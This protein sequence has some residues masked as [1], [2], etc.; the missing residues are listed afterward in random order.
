MRGIGSQFLVAAQL[1]KEEA[2]QPAGIATIQ[3]LESRIAAC[4]SLR[5]Q[6]LI[7][8]VAQGF[9]IKDAHSSIGSVLM[10]TRLFFSFF[11]CSS[12]LFLFV[13]SSTFGSI[14]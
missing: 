12:N 5:H 10:S 14:L 6:L 7:G 4:R 3:L 2:L 13:A 8:L 1:H 11:S 9:K